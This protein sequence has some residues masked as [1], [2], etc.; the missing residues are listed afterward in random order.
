MAEKARYWCAILYPENMI[1]T[2]Q[3][4]IA[5]ILQKP[6]CYGIHDKD[7]EKDGSP[8]KEHIHL[9]LPF[10]GPTTLK[11]VLTIANK[12]SKPGMTCCSTAEVINDMRY[13]YNYLLHDTDDA[14]KKHKYQYDKSNR[15]CVNGFDIGVY[16]QLSLQEKVE[17]TRELC[18]LI[19]EKRFV[20]LN[21]FY[22]YV[23]ANYDSK[24]FEIYEAKNSVFERMTRANYQKWIAGSQSRK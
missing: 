13:M 16:E 3:D 2:W 5:H 22:A 23:S 17:M 8:R 6:A 24:Y 12:L 1:D 21:D 10:D 18:D 14:R 4:D 7:L 15:V 19:I 20:N 11:N 9:M